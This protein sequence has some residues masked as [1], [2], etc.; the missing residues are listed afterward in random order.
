MNVTE[1]W[2]GERTRIINADWIVMGC[3]EEKEKDADLL[4]EELLVSNLP[5]QKIHQADHMACLEA[6][7]AG[8]EF[9]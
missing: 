8:F 3:N 5:D 7:I 1:F 6:R 9:L 2:D 4:G